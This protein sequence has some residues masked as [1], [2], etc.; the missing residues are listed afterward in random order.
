V[1]ELIDKVLSSD[2]RWVVALCEILAEK[3]MPARMTNRV[4][5]TVLGT[6][7]WICCRL[8][9]ARVSISSKVSCLTVDMLYA[10]TDAANI[11]SSVP[12]T[13]FLARKGSRARLSAG[14]TPLAPHMRTDNQLKRTNIGERNTD[15]TV[16][17]IRECHNVAY[18]DNSAGS[19]LRKLSPYFPGGKKSG[20][21][22]SFRPSFAK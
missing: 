7:A 14:E 16:W 20:E 10:Q 11:T 8:S 15:I 21:P 6:A 18:L 1:E 5:N 3:M 17:A 2:A 12:V 22:L 4:G 9:V 13:A 19:R